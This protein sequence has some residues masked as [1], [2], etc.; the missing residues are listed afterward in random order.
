MSGSKRSDEGVLIIDH[1]NSPGV[2]DHWIP[3]ASE[4]PVGCGQGLV[5]VPTYTCEH[6]PQVV[7]MNPNRRRPRGYCKK[8]DG[9]I[10]DRCNGILAA[11]RECTPYAKLLDDL[12]E[13][14]LKEPKDEHKIISSTNINPDRIR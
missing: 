5:E 3:G 8:C 2:P 10:C 6:C 14:A 1:R 11:T 12:Q 7:V 9:Y 13:H 4:L